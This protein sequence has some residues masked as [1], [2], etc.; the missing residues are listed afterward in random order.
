MKRNSFKARSPEIASQFSVSVVILVH[1][2]EL[3]PSH[4]APSHS[5][6]V[7]AGDAPDCWNLNSNLPVTESISAPKTFL[8]AFSAALMARVNTAGRKAH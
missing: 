4:S 6:I 5:L 1:I 7:S 8:P 3:D 2:I